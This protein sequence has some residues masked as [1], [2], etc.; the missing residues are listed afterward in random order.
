MSEAGNKTLWAAKYK[1][2][3]FIDHFSIQPTK[4]ECK[5]A[6]EADFG[7]PWDDC[8]AAGWTC[9]KVQVVEVMNEPA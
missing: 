6:F 5:T 1:P 9:V 3:G 7:H 2:D 8:Q 4:K